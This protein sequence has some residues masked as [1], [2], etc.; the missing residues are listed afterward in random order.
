ME[1]SVDYYKF[2]GGPGWESL[3]YTMLQVYVEFC[4]YWLSF[5]RWSFYDFYISEELIFLTGCERYFTSALRRAGAMF[6]VS[7]HIWL[8][9]VFFS[10]FWVSC[11]CENSVMA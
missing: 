10:T 9:V 4:K 5:K 3:A 6:G 11:I 2:P 1:L 7:Y 8:T